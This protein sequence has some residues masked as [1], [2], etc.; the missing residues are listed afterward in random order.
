[1]DI[2]PPAPA[3]LP[4]APEVQLPDFSL[5]PT[6][7]YATRT[8]TKALHNALKDVLE[9]QERTR[10]V[11]RGWVVDLEGISNLYQWTVRLTDFEETLPL[12]MD[13]REKGIADQ[14][15][16]LEVRFG[17]DFPTT[18]PYIRVMRPRLL[19][20][21]NGGGGH[22]TAGGSI[23]LEILTS[24]GWKKDYSLPSIFLERLEHSVLRT[25]GNECLREGREG[26]WMEG[27]ERVDGVVYAVKFNKG[28]NYEEWYEVFGQL[29]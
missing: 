14:G 29:M 7:T 3:P 27:S 13:M 24:T 22:V 28:A 19:Q 9:Y 5:M 20:F 12:Q 16:V 6:P 26:S 2:D 15:V 21:V 23:C 1:M 11:E 18:P 17:P 8:A 10:K 25:R 4:P